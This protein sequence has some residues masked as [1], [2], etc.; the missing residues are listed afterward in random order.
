MVNLGE[1]NEFLMVKKK[2][3]LTVEVSVLDT[4]QRL[5]ADIHSRQFILLPFL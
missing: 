2:A 4:D 3:Y 5:S 1:S